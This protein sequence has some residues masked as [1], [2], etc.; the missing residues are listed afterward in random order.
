VKLREGK[1][2]R[3]RCHTGHA[4]THSALLDGIMEHTGKMLWQVIRS[5][6][7]GVMLL[8]QMAQHMREEGNP[9]R[10]TV[11]S[12]NARELEKRS[13][14]FHEITLKQIAL[15]GDNVGRPSTDEA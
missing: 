5:M 11:Y 1:S 14:V 6:E 9:R 4:F 12:K 8:D 13:K 7:E 2:T 15:S 10:A 3:Y